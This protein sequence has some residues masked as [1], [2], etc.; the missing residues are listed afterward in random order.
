MPSSSAVL[1]K[2]EPPAIPLPEQV[3]T[4]IVVLPDEVDQNGVGLYPD[5]ALSLVKEL[6][7]LG[8]TAQYQHAQDARNWTGEKGFGAV[9]AN[10][11]LGIASN[12]GWAALCVLLRRGKDKA[13]VRIRLARCTQ[14]ASQITWDWFEVEGEKAEIADIIERLGF[15]PRPPEPGIEE[16]D[17][18]D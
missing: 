6:R 2:G 18:T 17:E 7:S 5:S 14:S 4:D 1:N 16:A 9:A 10:W 12:A 11:I 15:T 3:E 13:H 8:V